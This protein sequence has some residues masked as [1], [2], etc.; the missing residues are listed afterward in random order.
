METLPLKITKVN[1]NLSKDGP[2]HTLATG[3][4]I[5]NSALK[6]RIRVMDGVNGPFA[7]LPNFRIGE[8]KDAKF[9]DYIFFGGDNPKALRDD[10]NAKVVA[11]YNHIV[12]QYEDAEAV[13]VNQAATSTDA[14]DDTP[15]DE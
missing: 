14:D 2:A 13:E 4:V 15:F 3:Q 5:Y 8:G 12:T 11:E 1:L 9:I 7:K 10:L 6:I